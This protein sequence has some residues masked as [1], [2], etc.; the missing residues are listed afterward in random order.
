[1]RSLALSSFLLLAAAG[2]AP[3]QE[4]HPLAFGPFRDRPG[5]E[6]FTGRMVVRPV[7]KDAL[8]RRGLSAE[9]A[10]RA[11]EAAAAFLDEWRIKYY[12]DVDEHVVALPDGW[13]ENSFARLLEGTGDYEYATPDFR[14]F[15]LVAPNDPLYGQQWQHQNMNSEA[16]WDLHTGDGQTI[17]AFIDTGID[18]NH[19]DL[20]NRVSGYNSVSDL[21]ESSGGQV[22]DVMWHGSA[23]SGCI[24]ATGNNGI[25]VTG[26]SW[27]NR[28]MPIRTTDSPGGGAYLTD[29]LEGA[30]WAVQNGARTASASYSGVSYPEVGTTGTEV[31]NLGG[32]FFYAAGNEGWDWG[33]FDYPDTEVIGATDINDNRAWFSSWG[34]VVDVVAP[35]DN[36]YTTMLGSTYTFTSGTSFSTPHANGIASMIWSANPFLTPNEVEARLFACCDDLGAAG[37]DRVYGWGLVNLRRAIE[38]AVTGSMALTVPATLTH[39]QSTTITASGATPFATVYFYYSTTG[40]Q[41]TVLPA[42]QTSVGLR[43]PVQGGVI[44]ANGAGSATLVRNVPN[45]AAGR[46]VWIQAAELG[47]SSDIEFRVIQ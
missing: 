13:D 8:L 17:A 45:N 36:I 21:P 40:M 6:E 5:Y 39:G 42:L 30:R 16:G 24:A 28:L 3:A 2:I 22:F 14:C 10:T 46:N 20:Q 35:G 19:P 33:G 7:Q 31:K 41:A 18:L 25:G 38:L 15:P 12:A 1:M 34:D 47:N 9:A 26:V 44:A 11:R 43:N 29:I 27:S 4:R 32:L 23:V 37:N